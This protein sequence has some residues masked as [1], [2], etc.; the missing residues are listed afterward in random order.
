[1]KVNIRLN[2][3]QETVYNAFLELMSATDRE[4]QESLGLDERNNVSP[5]RNELVKKGLIVK[6][7]FRKVDGRKV[8]V[9]GLPNMYLSKDE[10]KIRWQH[11]IHLKCIALSVV[12]GLNI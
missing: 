4:I 10:L 3:S 6:H 8:H 11:G 7:G 5:R 1:M 9:W 2:K 12:K